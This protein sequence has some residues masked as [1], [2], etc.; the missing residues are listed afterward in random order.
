MRLIAGF[1]SDCS[2]THDNCLR[3][4][5]IPVG[6][7]DSRLTTLS[8]LYNLCEDHWHK[9]CAS[10]EQS[11]RGTFFSDVTAI[12]ALNCCQR[13]KPCLCWGNEQLSHGLRCVWG[14]WKVVSTSQMDTGAW[15]ACIVS[16]LGE[17]G[18]EAGEF[19]PRDKARA[20]GSRRAMIDHE[21]IYVA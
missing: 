2:D 9:I 15:S 17:S 18:V 8:W 21:D 20:V 19:D 4:H 7:K 13:K 11:H 14:I 10:P 1:G 12:H 16:N 5:R 6:P 3:W